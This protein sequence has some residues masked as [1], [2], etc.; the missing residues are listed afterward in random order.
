M[1]QHLTSAE[2]EF[3]FGELVCRE[4]PRPNAILDKFFAPGADFQ[5]PGG[6]S[7]KMAPGT[8]RWLSYAEH[9]GPEILQ[10]FPP[11]CKY[12]SSI[13]TPCGMLDRR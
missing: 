2:H 13:L 7:V 5:F 8:D 4:T 11:D 6:L 1:L 9:T 3:V 12:L 10:L